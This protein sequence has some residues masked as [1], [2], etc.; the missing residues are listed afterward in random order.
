[1]NIQFYLFFMEKDKKTNLKAC[2]HVSGTNSGLRFLIAVM[3]SFEKGEMKP[4]R[5]RWGLS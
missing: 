4:N 1:M 5:Q 3:F 2:R